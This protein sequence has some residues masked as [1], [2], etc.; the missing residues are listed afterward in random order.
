MLKCLDDSGRKTWVTD[1]KN[2]LYEHGF[3]N[4]W[5]AQEAGN[6]KHFYISCKLDFKTVLCKSCSLI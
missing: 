1:V 6:T 3:G 4:A 5:L 2:M